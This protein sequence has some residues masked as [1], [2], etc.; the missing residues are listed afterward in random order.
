MNTRAFSRREMLIRGSAW[1]TAL[2]L[3]ETSWWAQAFP[4]RPGEDVISWLDQP[5]ENP[6]GGVVENLPRWE[7]LA[8]WITPNDKFFRVAHYNKPVIDAKAWDLAITGLVKKPMTLT[9]PA[10][11][12]LPRQEVVSTRS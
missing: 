7:D 6:S 5:P 9:L 3:L 2:A 1:L 10:I 12:A 11:K 4:G 8:W